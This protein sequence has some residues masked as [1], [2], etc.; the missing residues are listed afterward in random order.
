[1]QT[2][3]GSSET[4]ELLPATDAAAGHSITVP[5]PGSVIDASLLPIPYSPDHIPL[6]SIGGASQTSPLCQECPFLIE[7]R[8][9][10]CER[11]YWRKMHQKVLERETKHLATIAEL[12][13]KVR[14]REQQL[15]GKKTEKSDASEKV[16]DQT[17]DRRN[18]GQQPGAPGHGRRSH[19]HLPAVEEIIDLPEE[20]KVCTQCHLPF[21]PFPGTEDSQEIEVE[22]KAYRRIIRRKRYKRTCTCNHLPMVITAPPV[23]KLIP[24]SSFGISIWVMV[25]LDKY[26]YQ[27]PTYR[28]VAQLQSYG[29][30]LCP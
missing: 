14:L 2:E 12:E 24:K 5:D 7:Y 18:R 27:H 1:M 21:S 29:L 22:V 16:S 4:I 23:P 8:K 15:F 13:A 17:L 6:P 25:L 9:A 26:L 3:R 19:D 10:V 20:E 30:H 28:L 11:S